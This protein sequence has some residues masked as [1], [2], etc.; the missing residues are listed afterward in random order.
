MLSKLSISEFANT[1]ASK[2][3]APGGGSAAALSG[4]MGTSLLEMVINLTLG[5]PEFAAQTELLTEKQTELARLH[6]ELLLLIDRDAAAFLALMD[7]YKLPKTS[8][9]EKQVRLTAIQ[10]GVKQ[11]AEVPLWTARSCLEVLEI[12]KSLLGK[13]NPHAAS[14]LV[15]G[16]LA[17]HTGIVGALLNTAI[18]IPLLKDEHLVSAYRGQIHLL[19]T[20]ADELIAEIQKEVYAGAP[21]DVMQEES[22]G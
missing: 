18:N 4:L 6:I 11:A 15:V 5:R 1:L 14:D 20:A 13:S 17:S 16:S 3:P 9:A 10:D 2:E 8:D 7:A 12:A 22:I 21:F 19:R